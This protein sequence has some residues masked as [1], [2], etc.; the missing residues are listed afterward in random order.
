MRDTLDYLEALEAYAKKT[1]P[2]LENLVI[3]F[4]SCDDVAMEG[5]INQAEKILESACELVP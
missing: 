5:F 1:L 2:L 3:A 4:D